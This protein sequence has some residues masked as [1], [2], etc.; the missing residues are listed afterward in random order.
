ME[1]RQKA[2]MNRLHLLFEATVVM[3]LVL[4]CAP[5][6]AALLTD[7]RLAQA[8]GSSVIEIASGSNYDHLGY[9]VVISK[10]GDV[11]SVPHVVD[12][13]QGSLWGRVV[14]V[15]E[16]E[17]DNPKWLK[18]QS[19]DAVEKQD[20]ALLKFTDG[21]GNGM[22]PAPF[23]LGAYGPRSSSS[24]AEYRFLSAPEKTRL[25]SVYSATA[26]VSGETN[27]GSIE[28]AG[29]AWVGHSGSPLFDQ[30]GALI[31]LVAEGTPGLFWMRPISAVSGWLRDRKGVAFS[32]LPPPPAKTKLLVRVDDDF[33]TLN[34]ITDYHLPLSEAMSE[35]GRYF[36]PQA[37]S[38][39]K[40][41]W[42][43]IAGRVFSDLL[44]RDEVK[45]DVRDYL[46]T[47]SVK[48]WLA[49]E[50]AFEIYLFVVNVRPDSVQYGL[51]RIE[52]QVKTVSL[53]INIGE[54]HPLISKERDYLYHV[55]VQETLDLLRQWPQLAR[56]KIVVADC[57]D[58]M[59]ANQREMWTDDRYE[60]FGT[61]LN[62]IWKDLSG[63]QHYTAISPKWQKCADLSETK[64]Q[65]FVPE[66]L[67]EI[68]IKVSF[69]ADRVRWQAS[70]AWDGKKK[71]P[72]IPNWRSIGRLNPEIIKKLPAELATEIGQSWDNI[73]KVAR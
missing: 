23:R 18:L 53:D 69:A 44:T 65:W 32:S 52:H 2:L 15:T 47:A 50:D 60:E 28:L 45:K 56:N 16:N 58:W 9:G 46:N 38:E 51:L 7:D 1:M 25:R 68:M 42:K 31:G 40:N 4:V 61:K 43:K 41:E 8:Q 62:D 30:T 34:N 37:Q 6:N 67:A 5:A 66:H 49:K 39:A 12:G 21:L 73:L 63:D 57:I 13:A 35:A 55:A 70:P 11:L 27:D 17:R 10:G 64:R 72:A 59:M 71:Y 22:A 54:K 20:I 19:V 36:S 29:P 24:P 14:P 48:D 33:A 26:T 3:L